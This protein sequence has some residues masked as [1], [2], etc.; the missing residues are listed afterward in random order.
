MHARYGELFPGSNSMSYSMFA[1]TY[2]SGRVLV[3]AAILNFSQPRRLS[4]P[5]ARPVARRDLELSIY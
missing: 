3:T 4:G 2:V 5:G 1:T